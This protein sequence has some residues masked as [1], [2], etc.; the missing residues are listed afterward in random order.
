MDETKEQ[1]IYKD[2]EKF[3]EYLREL[4]EQGISYYGDFDYPLEFYTPDAEGKMKEVE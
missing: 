1:P 2:S 4:A 3:K